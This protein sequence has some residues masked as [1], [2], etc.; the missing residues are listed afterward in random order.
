VPESTSL[1]K[2]TCAWATNEEAPGRDKDPI[3]AR[4]LRAI[5]EKLHYA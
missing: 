2:T 4:E 3:V 1:P 5:R